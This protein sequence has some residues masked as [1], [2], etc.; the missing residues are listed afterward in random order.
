MSESEVDLLKR[1]NIRLRDIIERTI[2]MARRYADGRMTYAVS[3]VNSAIDQIKEL[4]VEIKSDHTLTNPNYATDGIKEPSLTLIGRPEKKERV[5]VNL[6]RAE[7]GDQR[8]IDHW[9]KE[10]AEECDNEYRI[11]CVEIEVEE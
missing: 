7:C 8:W 10:D 3:D 1:E 4:G 6:Y 5:W 9:S 2:W 11:A